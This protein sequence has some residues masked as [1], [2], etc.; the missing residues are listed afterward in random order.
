M[1]FVQLGLRNR[2]VKVGGIGSPAIGGTGSPR[3]FGCSP[4]KIPKFVFCVFSRFDFALM[5]R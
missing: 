2:I 3:V 4:M 5:P 1:E